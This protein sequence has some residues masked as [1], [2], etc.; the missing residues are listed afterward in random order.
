MGA[1]AISAESS[2]SFDE[3]QL[4]IRLDRKLFTLWRWEVVTSLIQRLQQF[5]IGAKAE[6]DGLKGTGLQVRQ[7]TRRPWRHSALVLCQP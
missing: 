5:M 1:T 2:I 3:Q 4:I 6:D 7:I